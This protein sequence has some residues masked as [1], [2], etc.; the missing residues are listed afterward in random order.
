MECRDIVF[1]NAVYKRGKYIFKNKQ[2][3]TNFFSKL[4][5][6]DIHLYKFHQMEFN[7]EKLNILFSWYKLLEKMSFI[8]LISNIFFIGNNILMCLISL[9][10]I[11]CMLLSIYMKYKTL[12]FKVEMEITH[13]MLTDDVL[14]DAAKM[15]RIEKNF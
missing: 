11:V 6:T 13:Y 4:L 1:T 10:S 2:E 8:I 12:K 15:E 9:L 5:C 7:F 14:T 3:C